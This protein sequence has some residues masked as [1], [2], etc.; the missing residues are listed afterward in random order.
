MWLDEDLSAEVTARIE[1]LCALGSSLSNENPTLAIEKLREAFEILPE[2][3]EQWLAGTW[4]LTVIGDIAY[5]SGNLALAYDSFYGID[6]YEGWHANAFIRLR[7]GQVAFDRG[8]FQNAANELTFAFMAG[9]YEI[10]EHED[11]KYAEFVL[12][13]L[14]PPEPPVVHRLASYHLRKQK[15]W[16]QFW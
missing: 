4:I 13:R 16:W 2:P 6:L 11:D 12:S 3:R 14:L 7:R 10:L 15:Q 9:G 8:D 5:L 1:P